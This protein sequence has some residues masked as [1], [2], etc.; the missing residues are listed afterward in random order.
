MKQFNRWLL[1]VVVIC[2]GFGGYAQNNTCAMALTLSMGSN[3]A[4]IDPADSGWFEFQPLSSGYLTIN[5]CDRNNEELDT[6]VLVY[7]GTDCSNK[8]LLATS[9]DDCG[10]AAVLNDVPVIFGKTYYLYWDNKDNS[11]T[12]TFNFDASFRSSGVY[13]RPANDDV[14]SATP[15]TLGIA[16]TMQNNEDA[17]TQLGEGNI[18]IPLAAN[19]S[20]RGWQLDRRVKNSVWY[21]FVAPASGVVDIA[22]GST[23]FDAQLALFSGTCSN[24]GS[25]TL[26]GANDNLTSDP[27]HRNYCVTP[28]STYWIMVDGFA[29]TSGDF[30][31]I[32]DSGTFQEPLVLIDVVNGLPPRCP[33][34][35][36]FNFDAMVVD[37]ADSSMINDTDYTGSLKYSWKN[38]SNVEVGTSA[39]LT[40]KKAGTYTVTVT[41]TCGNQ[42]TAEATAIDT[43][44]QELVLTL[45]STANPGCI[46][47]P[48][49]VAVLSHTG[50]YL[51]EGPFS[52][53]DSLHYTYRKVN[54]PNASESA[55]MGI[56]PLTVGNLNL[57]TE[58]F[59]G[60][61]RVYVEDA[62]GN[63]DSVTFSLVDPTTADITLDSAD[64]A[65]PICPG[66]STGSINLFAAGGENTPLTY[67]WFK[68]T[69]GG[70]TWVPMGIYTQDLDNLTEGMYRVIVGDPCGQ[71]PDSIDFTLVD[72][73]ID[74]LDFTFTKTDP[75]TFNA[76]NGSINLNVTGGL[77]HYNA[78]WWVD[79]NLWEAYEDMLQLSNLKQG[80]Y[81][82]MITDTCSVAGDIDTTFILL[83]PIS[84]D[85]AC[86]AIT[87]SS[88]DSLTTYTNAGANANDMVTIPYSV[89]EGYDG[90]S[91]T[92]LD[93]TVWFKF[94]APLSGS[95]SF[96]VS[97]YQDMPSNLNFDAQVAV[98][99]A[100]SCN[101]PFTVLAANDNNFNGGP[102]N[103]SYLEVHCL[104]PGQ[105]YY[106]LVDGYQ[107]VGS[108]GLFDVDMDSLAV[109]DIEVSSAKV[110][111]TCIDAYGKITLYGITGGVYS[112]DPETYLYSLNLNGDSIGIVTV[113][114]GGN[115]NSLNGIPQSTIEFDSLVSG[116]YHVTVTDVCGNMYMSNDTIAPLQFEPF[117]L[118]YDLTKPDCPGEL[119]GSIEFVIGGGGTPGDYWWRIRKGVT[120]TG[121]DSGSANTSAV[122]AGLE[123]AE[124]YYVQ[125]Y[126]MCG[127][128][129]TKEF[130]VVLE[131]KVFDPFEAGVKTT[132]PTCPASADGTAQVLLL[133]GVGTATAQLRLEGVNVGS[134]EIVTGDFTFTGLDTGDYDVIVYDDCSVDSD[135]IPFTITDPIPTT[136][137]V[138]Y[139]TNNPTTFGGSDGEFS[140]T[141]EGGFPNYTVF[142]YE[143]DTI[144][145]S[146]VDTVAQINNLNENSLTT[147]TA[148]VAGYYR[149][150]LN[151]NCGNPNTPDN[152]IDFVLYNPPV[153]DKPCGATSLAT[154]GSMSM[155]TIN[156]A[157]VDAGEVNITPNGGGDCDG[158]QTWCYDNNINASVW[159]KFTVPASGSFNV[160]VNSAAFDPQVALYTIDTCDTYEGFMLLAANEDK[161]LSPINNNAYVEA[162][163]LTP[164][165]EVYVLVD[166]ADAGSGAFSIWVNQ[167][168]TTP[169]DI[170]ANIT[171]ASTEV[172]SDGSIDI[173][174]VGGVKPY[175]YNWS[176]G[177]TLSDRVGLKYGNISLTVTDKCGATKAKT[178]FVDYDMISNDEACNA[179]MLTVDGVNHITTNNKSTLQINETLIEPN[180]NST[181]CF[182]NM[183]WCR[184]D[185]LN[186]TVWFKFIAPDETITV[187]LCNNAQNEINT[188]IAVYSATDCADFGTFA[189]IGANDD[190]QDCAFGSVLNLTGLTPCQTYYVLVDSDQ[191]EKGEFGI[192]IRDNDPDINAGNDT[193]ISVCSGSGN[194][195][196]NN[197]HSDGTTPGKFFDDGETQSMA[198]GIVNTNVLAPGTYTFT[199]F[200][201][202]T[203][204]GQLAASDIA[205]FTVISKNCTGIDDVKGSNTFSVYPNPN[206][207]IFTIENTAADKLSFEVFDMTGKV[208]YRSASQAEAGAKTVVWL[209]APAKGVYTIRIN[210]EVSGSS[211]HRIVVQ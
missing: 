68:S 113:D 71:D 112:E 177:S 65:N 176:D 14:C 197:Y 13:S 63:I 51:H 178:Y 37:A 125:V 1:A 151:D 42:F 188:Q 201:G 92:A 117:T 202:D 7:E 103:D 150:A 72:P 3:G 194:L 87:I 54:T 156:G 56:T 49:G 167:I 118:D 200:V 98:L 199:Y 124:T 85:S 182:G 158:F 23:T 105:T 123:G 126:D 106:L 22:L 77:P 29:S 79:G 19:N 43:V 9:D 76:G 120:M 108:E 26:M 196:L 107:G 50:G 96:K 142:I 24:I 40:A 148:L 140:F 67:D 90:W 78:T 38:S 149:F 209:D 173:L 160:E 136:I 59:K 21:S 164:G 195:N 100:T 91:D 203:C 130:V 138:D 175:S 8:L 121:V 32:V 16:A 5:S 35:N 191:G 137:D 95:A 129:N 41:D 53:T 74:A 114:N 18:N 115:I 99:S 27:Y 17:T 47:D 210:G 58:L 57:F 119:N 165:T 139:A 155:G 15:L 31:I 205:V 204:A 97:H 101:G 159:Y 80:I 36:N 75:T 184:N 170:L 86:S 157:T 104:T 64:G 122:T 4:S 179:R 183:N 163:C 171:N 55:I 60:T 11:N 189:M 186:G 185:G 144:G 12:L 81:R 93:H 133:G 166:R 84:N 193:T 46:G 145:G 20:I 128:P 6:R 134:L 198:N 83:A 69:N 168:G 70:V 66:T 146:V 208:I 110:Q 127:N 89:D 132:D 30:D 206:S 131:D 61:Y 45:E 2:F 109:K 187:D 73:V 44:I 152:V 161:Q 147:Q 82:V 39:T 181:D 143:I 169:L 48:S 135:T 25:L 192:S 28:G 154:N 34:S 153:N 94:N 162:G 180:A 211:T 62:C 33:G 10:Q 52:A 111:P 141:I 88:N 207:G 116:I 174:V 190:T 102:V 172:S